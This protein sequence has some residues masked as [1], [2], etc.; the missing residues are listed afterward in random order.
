MED[1]PRV[2]LVVEQSWGESWPRMEEVKETDDRE[3]L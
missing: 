2:G 3:Y 1:V